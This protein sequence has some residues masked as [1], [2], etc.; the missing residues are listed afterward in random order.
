MKIKRMLSCALALALT[1]TMTALPAAAATFPDITNHWAKNYIEA[2]TNAGMFKGYDDGNFKPE[3]KLTTAEALALC[4]RAVPL[5]TNTGTR[6]GNERQED[7]NAILRGE[8]S[9]FYREFGICLELGILTETELRELY[10]GGGLTRS[11][12]KEDLSRYLVRAMQLGPMADRLKSYGMSFT[13]SASISAKNQPYVYLLNIYG[14]VQGDEHDAFLPKSD[15][16]RSVMATM[17]ARSIL[18]MTERGVSVDLPAYTT[19]EFKAGTISAVSE[20]ASGGKVLTLTSDLTGLTYASMNV[21]ADVVVYENNMTSGLSALKVGR[22]VR[23]ALNGRGTPTELRISGSLETLNGKVNGIDGNSIAISVDGMGR[24]VTMDRFTQVQVGTKTSAIGGP[25]LVDGNASYT[26]AVCKLDDQG[27]LVSIQLTGGTREESGIFSGTALGTGSLAGSTVLR[28]T[29]FDG[30]TRQYVVPTGTPLM[31]NGSAV[32]SLAGSSYTGSFVSVRVGNEENTA[33]MVSLDTMNKYIQGSIRGLDT[34]S[35]PRT[36]TI[37]NL[38]NG[39]S[40]DYDVP[41]EAVVT[42]NGEEISL[43]HLEKDYFVTAQVS[44]GE[45]LRLDA[46]PGSAVTEGTLTNRTFDGNSAVILEVTQADDNIVTFRVDLNDMPSIERNDEESAIDKLRMGD[47]VVITVR[48]SVVTR[49]RA[50]PQDANVIGTVDR[51]IQETVGSKMEMTLADG[52]KM[53]YTVNVST[54]VVQNGKE[55]GITALK[56]GQKLAMVV[57]GMDIS[58]A[59]I[60]QSSTVDGQIVGTIVYVNNNERELVLRVVNAAQVEELITVYAGGATVMEWN[61]VPAYLRDLKAGNTIQA[62]GQ[63]D[64]VNFVASLILRR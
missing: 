47:T 8:Q 14:I 10:Q 32:T 20:G 56:P 60:Q 44:G 41:S 40:A 27:R 23:A 6:I 61:G 11:V 38:A 17:L 64:G 52:S 62:N 15:V 63:Y 16:T 34:S 13:D 21:G 28:V 42:Y 25:S 51:I 59:E 50:T 30:V 45:I 58:S 39:R 18:F 48:Y 35:S 46:Y 55:V 2:M 57:N 7:V 49:I 43:R 36:V 22:H 24:I 4:A 1:L 37:T 19:Y 9:W 26:N 33:A 29:G 5:D 54:T 3:N 31:V 12:I 53:T